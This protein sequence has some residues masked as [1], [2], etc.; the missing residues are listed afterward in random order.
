MS[1]VLDA[2]AALAWPP[3][4]AG[5]HCDRLRQRLLRTGTGDATT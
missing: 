3:G 4:W 1:G 2:S 5:E